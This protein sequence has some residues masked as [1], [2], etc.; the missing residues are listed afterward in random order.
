LNLRQSGDQLEAIDNNGIVFNGTLSDSTLSSGTATAN[1]E[2][3]G[4]TTAGQS[5]TISG[6]LF[7]SGTSGIMKG[8]WI[9]PNRYCYVDGDAVINQVQT[10]QATALAI[11]PVGP[12]TLTGTGSQLFT[13]SGG[14][15]IFSSWSRSDAS[16]G[17]LT[18]LSGPTTTYQSNGS[19]GT[20]ILT[21]TDS[22]GA[23][24]S[25]TI[26]QP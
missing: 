7:G 4:Q 18:S 3:D 15:G 16:L 9:E 1:F 25:V 21:V 26:I 2:L 8:T 6:S 5:V 14:S 13:A 17:T 22:D 24:K 23:T 12:I 11:S 10:N 19:I 20:N